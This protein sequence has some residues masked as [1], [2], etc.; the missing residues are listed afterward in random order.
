MSFPTYSTNHRLAKISNMVNKL[1]DLPLS[2]SVP[3]VQP[4][5]ISYLYQ[6]IKMYFQANTDTNFQDIAAFRSSFAS[7]AEDARV[8]SRMSSIFDR[9]NEFATMLYTWRSISRTLPFIRSAD[10]PN[11]VEIYDKTLEILEPHAKKLLEF[12]RFQ[13][14]AI[15]FF[16]GEMQRLAQKDKNNCFVNQ[17]CL[18]MLG[19]MLKMF[20]VLDEIKNMKAS[21]KND[22]SAYKRAVQMRQAH[23]SDRTQEAQKLSLFLAQQKVI[24]D[25]LKQ[26]L[27][28]VPGFEDLLVEIVN[29]SVSMYETKTY[30]LP[31]EKHTLVMVMAF[32]LFLMDAPVKNPDGKL[33]G[34]TLSKMAK[35]INFSKIDRIFKECEVVNL[36]GDMSVEPFNYIKQTPSYEASKWPECNS[37][38]L[39]TQGNFLVHL[40]RFREEFSMLLADL[41]WHTNTTI[42]KVSE[43]SHAENRELYDL[44]LRGLQFL[45]GW[46]VQILDTFSWKLLHCADE[47]TNPECPRDAENY[48]KATRYNYSSDE[49]FAL[50][51]VVAMIK[52]MQ[53]HLLKLETTYSESIRR[54]IY[55][56]FHAVVIGQLTGPLL[57]AQKKRERANLLRLINAIQ[58]TGADAND[59]LEAFMESSSSSGTQSKSSK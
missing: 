57:K 26:K 19:K 49:R 45:S 23:D 50:L 28:K 7:S 13:A 10:Q 37:S 29:N 21:M 33:V 34:L 8:Y 25:T 56:E 39:S 22:F 31:E 24:R 20:A 3:C 43:R 38:K 52:S 32:S 42:M 4:S 15:D 58:A 55:Q 40:P 1:L 35:R 41:A 18:L 5:N 59:D 14:D 9:G 51:E 17:S 36:F 54:S 46:S 16:V 48:E 44:A 6:C 27:T 2:E 53:S 30:V 11:R 47:R 12:M